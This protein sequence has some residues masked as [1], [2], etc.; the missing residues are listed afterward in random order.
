MLPFFLALYTA[1]AE[2]SC[3]Y[4]RRYTVYDLTKKCL[5]AIKGGPLEEMLVYNSQHTAKFEFACPELKIRLLFWFFKEKK[6]SSLCGC[7]VCLPILAF[8]LAL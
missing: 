4:R 2:A 3:R 1:A 5:I 6:L 7:Q 8:F